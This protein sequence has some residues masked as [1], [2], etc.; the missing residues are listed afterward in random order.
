M[1]AQNQL[2]P[3]QNYRVSITIKQ[4]VPINA[5]LV[6]RGMNLSEYSKLAQSEYKKKALQG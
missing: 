5:K 4:E 6:V 1:A 3:T 2:L